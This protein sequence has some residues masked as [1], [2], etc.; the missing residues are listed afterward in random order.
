MQ[1]KRNNV[2]L[3]LDKLTIFIDEALAFG[4]K[5]LNAW[6]LLYFM[7]VI[8]S[9]SKDCITYLRPRT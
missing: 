6:A 7:F 1:S 4:L 8:L 3:T 9:C 5:L 2:A